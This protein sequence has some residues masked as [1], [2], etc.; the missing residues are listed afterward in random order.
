MAHATTDSCEC[1]EVFLLGLAETQ[2]SKD[3][4]VTIQLNAAIASALRAKE[5]VATSGRISFVLRTRT[6]EFGHMLTIYGYKG[7][8]SVVVEVACELLGEPYEMRDVAP[9]NPGPLVEELRA[10]NPLVQIPTVRLDDGSIMTE[11]VAILLWLLERHPESKWAPPVGDAKRP[12]FLR[13][14]VF[15]ASTIY[16]MYTVGDFPARWVD[17]EVA[18]KQLKE[19]SIRRTLDAWIMV[20]QALLPKQYFLGDDL[21]IVDVYAAMMSRWRPGR[22][23]IRDVAPLCMAAVE[24]TEKHEIVGNVFANNFNDAQVSL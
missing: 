4:S 23:R 17:G 5:N 8:G 11:S 15:F 12:A 3:H 13:W 9:W 10:L 16:P 7:C 1:I 20:E 14:L 21:T 6:C 2:K 19:A 22:E 18:Q 24:R